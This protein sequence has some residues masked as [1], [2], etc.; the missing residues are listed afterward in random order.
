MLNQIV[1]DTLLWLTNY[2]HNIGLSIV[3]FTILLKI[4]FLPATQ[5]SIKS[6][7][8]MKELQP[9]IK[10][11]QIKYKKNPQA[12]Q[13]A[14]MEL[15][16]KSK[17]NPA[18]GCLPQLIQLALLIVLYQALLYFFKQVDGNSFG[19]SLRF[20]WFDISKPDKLYILPLLT[21]LSQFGLSWL[22]AWTGE[23]NKIVKEKKLVKKPGLSG[24]IVDTLGQTQKQML[25]L[26]PVMT[27]LISISLPSG[28]VIYWLVSSLFGLVQQAYLMR[29]KIFKKVKI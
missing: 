27:G 10:K 13:K 20:L 26:M 8:K 14:Q 28:L 25:Y 12:L 18:A 4:V 3:V 2:T 22:M 17:I 7:Q 16:K 29:N 15:Y 21:A 23:K 19:L 24:E 9:E 1:L 5:A 6:A 11:L